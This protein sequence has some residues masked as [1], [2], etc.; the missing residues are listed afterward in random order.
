[1][2][3]VEIEE[4][5]SRLAEQP[6]DSAE[7]STPNGL[8]ALYKLITEPFAASG[9][10]NRMNVSST[11]RATLGS[12]SSLEISSADLYNKGLNVSFVLRG[13]G[14]CFIRDSTSSEILWII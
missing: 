14:N 3:A 1:M 2:N 11:R 6:F 12:S 5:I 7:W 8:M 4:A 13:T 10:L 9:N